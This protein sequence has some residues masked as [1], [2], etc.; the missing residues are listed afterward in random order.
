M[1]REIEKYRGNI[2]EREREEFDSF[3]DQAFSTCRDISIRSI[4]AYNNVRRRLMTDVNDLMEREREERK[5]FS[6]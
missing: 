4:C 5:I 6:T 2:E 3:E 1:T